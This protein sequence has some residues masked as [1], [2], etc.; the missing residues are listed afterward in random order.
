MFRY[1]TVITYILI[2]CLI[3]NAVLGAQANKVQGDKLKALQQARLESA[4][5]LHEYVVKN[6]PVAGP[7]DNPERIPIAA[8]VDAKR[9]LLKAQLEEAATKA[10]RLKVFE[11]MLKD[12]IIFEDRVKKYAEGFV[13]PYEALRYTA[14]LRELELTFEREKKAK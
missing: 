4:A 14:W 10:E 2:L 12:S 13:Q 8:V 11:K 7:K 5:K 6:Y 1:L 3:E 9:L